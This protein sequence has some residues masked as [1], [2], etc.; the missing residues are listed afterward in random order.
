M[1]SKASLGHL[2]LVVPDHLRKTHFDRPAGLPVEGLLSTRRIGAAPLWVVL[3]EAF[4]DDID[5][6]RDWFAIG[7]LDLL[8]DIA[9]KLR[10]LEYSKLVPVTDVDRTRLG[11]VHERDQPIDQVVDVLER[12]RLRAV[13]VDS[14]VL[15]AQCLHDEVGHDAPVVWVHWAQAHVRA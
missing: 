12:A 1:H 5:A 3:G 10:K 11:R 7:A 9:D 2:G 15:S 8:D 4:M 14:Q 6:A 13:A